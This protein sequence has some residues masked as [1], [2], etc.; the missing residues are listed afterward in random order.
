MRNCTTYPADTFLGK[1]PQPG[2][3]DSR[4][5]SGLLGGS[6]GRAHERLS[7][8]GS[9]PGRP[10]GLIV[11]ERKQLDFDRLPFDPLDSLDFSSAELQISYLSHLKSKPAIPRLES[12]SPFTH[13]ACKR[14]AGSESTARDETT[15]LT[16]PLDANPA[17]R[18]PP[19]ARKA[20]S[21]VKYLLK[22]LDFLY[23]FFKDSLSCQLE[24][25]SRESGLPVT[26]LQLWL[27]QRDFILETALKL[28]DSLEV[29]Q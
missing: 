28:K 11:R 4:L 6:G 8:L 9:T 21:Q 12:A 14:D 29:D 16:K 25:I 24:E 19:F 20:V 18:K 27:E 1:R 13:Q 3:R 22:A 7:A 2:G 26:I 15:S 10:H 5:G 17:L 23:Y